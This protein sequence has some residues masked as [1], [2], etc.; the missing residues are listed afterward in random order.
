MLRIISHNVNG[1]RA[2]LSKYGYSEAI[3]RMAPD[4]LCLQEVRAKED[5]LPTSVLSTDYTGYFSVHDKPGY[6]GTAIFIRKELF[7]PLFHMDGRAV[8]FEG[9]RVEILDFKH[10]K[11]VSSY[12]PN[13]GRAGEKLDA[14]LKFEDTLRQY[15]ASNSD[16]KPFIVCGDLNV[17][18]TAEDTN[19]K[20]VAGTTPGERNA[21]FTLKKDAGLIDVLRNFN[22][23]EEIFTWHS[24]MYNAKENGKGMRLDHFLVSKEL[25]DYVADIYVL[26][27]DEF[28]CHSD[29]LPV[30][31]NIDIDLM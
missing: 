8:G 17:A 13:V 5:Q 19:V 3:R 6:A 30:V 22:P 9:G 14:R 28:A 15:V 31:M 29:H 25:M 20:S 1:L 24:N 12:S 23:D 2:R 26:K 27:D 21:F 4:I 18:P 7:E 11:L 10:F 16:L